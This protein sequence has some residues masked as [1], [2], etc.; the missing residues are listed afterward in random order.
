MENKE[1]F[2][3]GIY[4]SGL[5]GLF[6]LKE[7]RT[8]LNEYSY[9]FLADEKNLPYGTKTP[10]ELLEYAKK[11]LTYLFQKELCKIVLI[12]CN[13]LS[14]TVFHE[15]KKWASEIF[16]DRIILDM[17]QPT[18]DSI[19]PDQ[20]FVIFGTPR[21]IKSDVYQKGLIKKYSDAIVVGIEVPLLASMIEQKK[22]SL[23]YLKDTVGKIVETKGSILL[24]CTHYGIIKELFYKLFPDARVIYSQEVSITEYFSDYITK[25]EFQ[26][27][28]VKDGSLKILLS[29]ENKIFQEYSK[30]W[31]KDILVPITILE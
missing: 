15:L 12:A 25:S 20:E 21:T 29:K 13:T 2:K 14:T 19:N 16:P 9:V 28:L 7:I 26:G 27:S 18:L 11:C 1:K 6:M 30:E 22:D 8:Q 24:C 3:I 10:E 17:V 4:D 23:E 31:F 5:G